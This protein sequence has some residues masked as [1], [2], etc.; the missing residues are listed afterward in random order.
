MD[1]ETGPRFILPYTYLNDLCQEEVVTPLSTAF[2]L[3]NKLSEEKRKEGFSTSA[4]CFKLHGFDLEDNLDDWSDLD[5]PKKPSTGEGGGWS[6]KDL[7]DILGD[8]EY[9]PDKNKERWDHITTTTARRP[10]TTRALS[11]PTELDGFDLEDSLDDWNDLDG[12][13][14]PSTGER[15]GWSDK[16]LEDILGDGEYK[17]DK[18]KG[19]NVALSGNTWILLKMLTIQ[20][21]GK[22]VTLS[23]WQI[24][25]RHVHLSCAVGSHSC[26]W[27][28]I[29]EPSWDATH[30]LCCSLSLSWCPHYLGAPRK[31]VFH[32]VQGFKLNMAHILKKPLANQ[33]FTKFLWIP[34]PLPRGNTSLLLDPRKWKLSLGCIV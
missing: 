22:H 12:P 19:R 29:C 18:N 31:P 27:G 5:G 2:Q 9:K 3:H 26:G 10:G 17:P 33:M 13:K 32:A 25:L 20:P 24:R 34:F 8:G 6:D 14:T 21:P 4:T 23:L 15:G 11:N 28:L 7:E 16:D 1:W 30:L